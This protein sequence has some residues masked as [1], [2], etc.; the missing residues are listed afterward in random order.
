VDALAAV[1]RHSDACAAYDLQLSTSISLAGLPQPL[2]AGVPP[3]AAPLAPLV[4]VRPLSTSKH[5]SMKPGSNEA[6]KLAWEIAD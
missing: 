3:A 2:L 5:Q 1:V 4:T 6:V